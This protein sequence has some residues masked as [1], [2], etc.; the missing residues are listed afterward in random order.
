MPKRKRE[1]KKTKPSSDSS[2]ECEDSQDQRTLHFRP[3][4]VPVSTN[5]DSTD[6]RPLSEIELMSHDS[7][8]SLLL[9]LQ[10][11]PPSKANAYSSCPVPWEP[12][13]SLQDEECGEEKDGEA[14]ESVMR[15][16]KMPSTKAIKT[17]EMY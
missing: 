13:P 16:T 12:I 10:G 5:Q 9:H 1:A 6:E 2:P 8:H 11:C 14:P 17:E 3:L 15:K 7:S 4:P